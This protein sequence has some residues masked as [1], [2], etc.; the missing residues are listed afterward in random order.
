MRIDGTGKWIFF[1]NLHSVGRERCK[2]LLCIVVNDI[3]TRSNCAIQACKTTIK[4][5]E[6][7]IMNVVEKNKKKAHKKW[8]T[9]TDHKT[10]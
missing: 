6:Q 9:T 10:F 2:N 7:I 3:D 8:L 5:E 1:S 4:I